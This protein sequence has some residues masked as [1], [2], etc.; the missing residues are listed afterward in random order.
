MHNIVPTDFPKRLGP[1]ELAGERV[2]GRQVSG[3]H[4][5]AAGGRRAAVGGRAASGRG[6]T[7]AGAGERGRA[8]AGRQTTS[9]EFE[10]K[11]RPCLLGALWEPFGHPLVVLAVRPSPKR[12]CMGYYDST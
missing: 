12:R 8:G 2:P 9:Y 4:T 5:G 7:R 3:R 1:S 6:R 10:E 11:A